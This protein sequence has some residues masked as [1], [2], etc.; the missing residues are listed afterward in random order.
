MDSG[1]EIRVVFCDISKAFD[2]VWHRG[3]LFKLKQS[4]ISGNL[5]NWF[6][7]YLSG[8]SQRVVINGS[9]SDWLSINA[10]VPQGFSILGPLLFIIFINDIVQDIDAQIKLFKI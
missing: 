5:L 10:G 3:L 4:G 6:E 7:N 9:N 2:R 8:R 1:K